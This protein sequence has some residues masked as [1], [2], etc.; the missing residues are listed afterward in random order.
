GF[1]NAS[2]SCS[3]NDI[4]RCGTWIGIYNH[5]TGSEKIPVDGVNPFFKTNQSIPTTDIAFLDKDGTGGHTILTPGTD[6]DYTSDTGVVM[7]FGAELT[8]YFGL[9]DMMVGDSSCNE[10]EMQFPKSLQGGSSQGAIFV[11][12]VDGTRLN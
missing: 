11:Q 5:N 3:E 7:Y 1:L 10:W 9:C 6:R 4:Y 2:A 12:Y 8:S